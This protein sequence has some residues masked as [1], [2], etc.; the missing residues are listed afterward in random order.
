MRLLPENGPKVE[1]H[2]GGTFRWDPRK[3][4]DEMSDSCQD[5]L[6]SLIGKQMTAVSFVLDYINFQFEDAFL[7]ALSLPYVQANQGKL[8]YGAAG[9]RDMLCERISHKVTAASEIEE[10]EIRITFDDGSVI[11]IPLGLEEY[12]GVEAAILQ[13]GPEIKCV[14]RPE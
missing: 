7:T 3:L 13:I 1:L 12:R 5:L 2:L 6:A 8:S 9:Y 4:E 14:W 11:A 10:Q